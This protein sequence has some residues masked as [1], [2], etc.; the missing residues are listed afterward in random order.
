ML[1]KNS[2]VR[3]KKP[4]QKLINDSIYTQYYNII[5][6]DDK[7]MHTK[8]NVQLKISVVNIAI[9]ARCIYI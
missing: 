2:V 1:V 8:Q 6:M 3:K 5:S 9:Q 4:K 7:T